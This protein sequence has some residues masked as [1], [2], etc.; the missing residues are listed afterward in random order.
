[1]NNDQ[2]KSHDSTRRAF[3]RGSAATGVGLA[4]AVIA[5]SAIAAAD[6]GINREKEAKEQKGYHLSSHIVDYYKTIAS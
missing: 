1:M 4:T 3:L 5:P 2:N 6:E